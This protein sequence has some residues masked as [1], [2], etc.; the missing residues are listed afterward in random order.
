MIQSLFLCM[1]PP[2]LFDSRLMMALLHHHYVAGSAHTTVNLYLKRTGLFAYC[3]AQHKNT[4]VLY[5]LAPK[6]YIIL[7]LPEQFRA[8]LQHLHPLLPFE[9]TELYYSMNKLS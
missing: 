7:L 8:I 1:F 3:I 9:G 2:G 4:Q 6:V 5:P